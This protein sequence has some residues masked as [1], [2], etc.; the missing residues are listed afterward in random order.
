MSP[1]IVNLVKIDDEFFIEKL[2][3]KE[4]L[5]EELLN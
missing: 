2:I 4:M 3:K 5:D 1:S